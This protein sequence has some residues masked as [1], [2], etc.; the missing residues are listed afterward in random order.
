MFI[1]LKWILP[2]SQEIIPI[3]LSKRYTI[4]T[5]D[6]VCDTIW[7]DLWFFVLAK[8]LPRPEAVR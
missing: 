3:I 7:D 1:Y 2:L 4:P 5:W 6:L 8:H